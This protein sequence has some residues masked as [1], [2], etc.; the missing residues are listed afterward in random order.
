MWWTMFLGDLMK[1]VSLREDVHNYEIQE[2]LYIT[3]PL[4]SFLSLPPSHFLPPPSPIF[5]TQNAIPPSFFFR[6]KKSKERRNGILYF[7]VYHWTWSPRVQIIL[8]HTKRCQAV[9]TSER[10]RGGAREKDEI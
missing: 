7:K 3:P 1:G 10:E 5:Q 2:L 8:H 9:D 6:L 4:F